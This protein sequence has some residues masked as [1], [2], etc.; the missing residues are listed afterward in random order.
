[1]FMNIG[2][3]I[4]MSIAACSKGLSLVKDVPLEAIP[5]FIIGALSHNLCAVFINLMI[6][7]LPLAVND[8][9][10]ALS[11]FITALLVRTVLGESI[12]SAT[13]IAMIMSFA[14]VTVLA[15]FK[16]EEEI[17]T[18]SDTPSYTYTAGITFSILCVLAGSIN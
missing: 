13:V 12:S 17:S 4:V 18:D 5:S 16:P 9:F 11:P 14:A 1:M 2:V 3:A 8:A 15:L 10:W 6:L 7:S